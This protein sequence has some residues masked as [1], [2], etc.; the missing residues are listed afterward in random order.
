MLYEGSTVG[1]ALVIIWPYAV[2]V[3]ISTFVLH[4]HDQH[5]QHVDSCQSESLGLTVVALIFAAG[6]RTHQDL[7]SSLFVNHGPAVYIDGPSPQMLG[8]GVG[9]IAQLR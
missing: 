6:Y 9:A 3:S 7:E 2:L 1:N 8:S 5:P 4:Q